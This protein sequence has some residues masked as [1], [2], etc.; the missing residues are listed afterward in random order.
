M[1]DRDPAAAAE[2]RRRVFGEAAE[3]GT[4]IA[5]AHFP[6]PFGTVGRDDGGLSWSP[7]A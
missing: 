3:D 5:P 4:R 7:V 1:G 6:R 2:T